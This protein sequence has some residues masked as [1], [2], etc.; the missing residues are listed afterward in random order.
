MCSK[1]KQ[2]AVIICSNNAKKQNDVF[3]LKNRLFVCWLFAFCSTICA[4]GFVILVNTV[5]NLENLRKKSDFVV[6][7]TLVTA[8]NMDLVVNSVALTMLFKFGELLYRKICGICV[9]RK[10]R[11]VI[12]HKKIHVLMLRL[13]QKFQR[14]IYEVN[15]NNTKSSSQS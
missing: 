9:L 8:V 11:I 7:P 12:N 10:S 5:F 15:N 13:S 1:L 4:H 3:W 6:M 14:L 2:F